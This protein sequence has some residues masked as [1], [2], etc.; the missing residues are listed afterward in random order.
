MVLHSA[1]LKQLR[2]PP[3]P[4]ANMTCCN[5]LREISEVSGDYQ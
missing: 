2:E 5:W 3:A 1:I 4:C